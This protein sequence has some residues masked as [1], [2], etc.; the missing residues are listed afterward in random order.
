MQTLSTNMRG[1]LSDAL[2]SCMFNNVSEA[3][4]KNSWG[5]LLCLVLSVALSFCM[6]F[7]QSIHCDGSKFAPP[8]WTWCLVKLSS[9]STE[10]SLPLSVPADG[11]QQMLNF[12]GRAPTPLSFTS[13]FLYFLSM[14]STVFNS[15]N[16]NLTCRYF[17][18][19]GSEKRTFEGHSD[20]CRR[21]YLYQYTGPLCNFILEQWKTKKSPENSPARVEEIERKRN[22]RLGEGKK[23]SWRRIRNGV[24]AFQKTYFGFKQ[25]SAFVCLTLGFGLFA[26]LDNSLFPIRSITN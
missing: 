11:F 23:K 15:P 7:L 13:L 19:L 22:G 20:M 14:L 10:P 12:S 18:W 1:K 24:L 26:Y 2:E 9:A 17:L 5:S 25:N 21:T 16:L 6:S 3:A 4:F 8:A